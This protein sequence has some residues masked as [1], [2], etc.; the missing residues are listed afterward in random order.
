MTRTWRDAEV[1]PHTRGWTP[2]LSITGS[3]ARGFPAHAGMD[4][5]PLGHADGADGFPR[6]RGDGPRSIA[7][8]QNGIWVSPHTRGWDP[9]DQRA[10]QPDPG[11][12]RTRGDG[13]ASAAM[14]AA[15]VVVSPH[16]RGWT[17]VFGRWGSIR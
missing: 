6:T 16:T 2:C 10:G 7:L 15:A 14:L 8:S 5:H 13:P 11:F 12:P 3:R 17:R 1:S 9:L 4:P